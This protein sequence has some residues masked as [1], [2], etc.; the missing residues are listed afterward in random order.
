MS[1]FIRTIERTSK[2]KFNKLGKGIGVH[3]NLRGS[4][5]GTKNPKD[6]CLPG[7][8]KKKPK[9]W[10]A[11]HKVTPAMLGKQQV[12]SV[13]QPLAPRLTKADRHEA[14]RDRMT[15]KAKRRAAEHA[16]AVRADRVER[17]LGTPAG[18]NRSTGKPHKHAAERARR[19]RQ[20]G[21]I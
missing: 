21:G 4:K 5:L 2:R 19:Q 13:P 20:A 8:A 15:S 9:A 12:F 16:L 7:V 1:S 10:R 18:I 6:T 14:H 11:K 17:L 3:F